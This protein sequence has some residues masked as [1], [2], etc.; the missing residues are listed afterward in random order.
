MI[1]MGQQI[2]PHKAFMAISP[3]T[4]EQVLKDMQDFGATGVWPAGGPPEWVKRCADAYVVRTTDGLVREYAY[5]YV[6]DRLINDGTSRESKLG[7]E[8]AF[9]R[10]AINSEA[11]IVEAHLDYKSFPKTRRK[12][13][14]EQVERMRRLARSGELTAEEHDR[15]R[16]YPVDRN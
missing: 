3:A 4:P 2:C 8:N 5:R 1:A 7:T 11:R 15:I 12:I 16:R 14:E 6:L 10:Q 13:A 9:L